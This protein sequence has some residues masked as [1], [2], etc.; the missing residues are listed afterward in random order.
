MNDKKL[1]IKKT[2]DHLHKFLLELE[3]IENGSLDDDL[4]LFQKHLI[5]V[6]NSIEVFL[7]GCIY[8]HLANSTD[9]S[10]V[11]RMMYRAGS[12]LSKLS[13]YEIVKVCYEIKIISKPEK[14]LLEEVNRCRNIFA[15]ANGFEKDLKKFENKEY[16]LKK[17]RLLLK[18]VTAVINVVNRHE[19]TLSSYQNDLLSKIMESSEN[20]S[21]N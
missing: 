2:T 18:A 15:H 16:Y 13:Y 20:K 7:Q 4:Q 12:V 19:N 5:F 14:S 21:K 1:G 3:T 6:H 9:D 11:V 17:L 8:K 10:K